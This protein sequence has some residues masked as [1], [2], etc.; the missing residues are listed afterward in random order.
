MPNAPTTIPGESFTSAELAGVAR[1]LFPHGPRLFRRLQHLRPRICPFERL[2]PF[3]PMGA[4]LLDVGCGGGLWPG[5]LC[6][7]GRVR[8]VIGFDSS[9]G[10]IALARSMHLPEGSVRP[11]FEHLPVQAPWPQ[12]PFTCVS[13]I[14]VMH[15]VPPGAQ[16]SLIELAASRLAPGGVLIYKDM[17]LRPRWRAWANRLHDLLMARQWI[18]YAPIAD[19]ERWALAAGLTL[20]HASSHNRL[21]YGHELRVFRKP[22]GATGR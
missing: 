22:A 20:E 10:A 19:V 13:V 17:C 6:R 7:L 1:G 8:S 16:A 15:H 2:I 12:G 5:L 4:D 3:V 14:D 21:W 18:R 9:A 11:R